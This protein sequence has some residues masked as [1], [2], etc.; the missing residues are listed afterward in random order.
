[1]ADELTPAPLNQAQPLQAQE[2]S[3]L[4]KLVWAV[5]GNESSHGTNVPPPGSPGARGPMQIE[6]D[7]FARF[8]QPGE[9]IDDNKDNMAVGR[10]ILG[11]YLQMYGDPAR[12]AVA[13]FSGEGNVAPPGSPTPWIHN[14]TDGGSTVAQYVA[15]IGYQMGDR[16]MV[17]MGSLGESGPMPLAPDPSILDSTLQFGQ[18]LAKAKTASATPAAEGSPV[19]AQRQRQRAPIQTPTPVPLQRPPPIQAARPLEVYQALLN[20]QNP[21]VSSG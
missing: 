18:D 11:H 4:D 10:R 1:M 9:Q 15:K 3:V 5:Y 16:G 14:G 21:L 17:H 20:R 13:Y 6:P 2:P 19:A 7:T 12:A 8:A